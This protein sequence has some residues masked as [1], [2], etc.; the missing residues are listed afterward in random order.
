M[1]CTK[2]HSPLVRKLAAQS[3]LL[4]GPPLQASP[5]RITRP[6]EPR[7][8]HS[9][10]R[11][12]PSGLDCHGN[13]GSRESSCGDD[14]ATGD[15]HRSHPQGWG[16]VFHCPL[17]FLQVSFPRTG[18]LEGRHLRPFQRVP[19]PEAPQVVGAQPS[20]V[21]RR[22]ADVPSPVSVSP[23]VPAAAARSPCHASSTAVLPTPRLVTTPPACSPDGRCARRWRPARRDPWRSRAPGR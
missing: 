5:R 13:G 16:V 19:T 2:R 21:G 18:A 8:M 17:P 23:H 3:S 10:P 15:A 20:E 9:S 14:A 7:R 22:A 6:Q 11:I 4:L 12:I 1:H